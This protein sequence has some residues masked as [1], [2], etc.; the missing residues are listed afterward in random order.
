VDCRPTVAPTN[1]PIDYP[2]DWGFAFSGIIA[3]PRSVKRRILEWIANARW[4]ETRVK[5]VEETARLAAKN[6]RANQ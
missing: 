1:A 6:I 3:F 5:R 2:L 4:P